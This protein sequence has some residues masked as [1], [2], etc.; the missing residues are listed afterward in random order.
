MK[1]KQKQD[2]VFTEQERTTMGRYYYTLRRIHERL[3]VE[4]YFLTG[5]KIWNIFK[6]GTCV[7]EAELEEN[8]QV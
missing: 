1:N 3:V 4:G 6:V 2:D 8:N 7:G 5:G